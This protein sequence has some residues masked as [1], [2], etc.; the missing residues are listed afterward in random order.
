MLY[1]PR[2]KMLFLLGAVLLLPGIG[3]CGTKVE[4][5]L[6]GLE[7]AEQ[8]NVLALMEINQRAGDEDLNEHVVNRLYR[9]APDQIEKA[10]QPF[11]Y[12]QVKVSSELEKPTA[13][14]AR[15]VAR[16]R[17][18]RGEPAK[19]DAVDYKVTGPGK[20]DAAFP[21]DFGMRP[22]DVLLHAEYEEAVRRLVDI[23]ARNG[24]LDADLETHRVVVDTVRNSARVDVELATGPRYYLGAVTFKQD[25]LD[26]D[27]LRRFVRFQP[28][29]AYDPGKLLGLQ[30]SLLGSEYF[31]QVE[32]VPRK[33][34][35]KDDVIPLDVVATP[36]KA[37]KYRIGGGYATDTGPRLRLDWTR[38]YVGREGHR[39]NAEINVSPALSYLRGEYRIPLEKPTQDM[40]FLRP[41]IE[42]YDT[43]TRSGSLYQFE[44]GHSVVL[45]SGWRRVLGLSYRYEDYKVTGVDQGITNELVPNLFLSKTVT[46]DPVVTR[47]GYRL[48]AGLLGALEQ[49]LSQTSYLSGTLFAKWIGTFGTDYRLITR[50]NLGVTLADSALDLPASR[51]FYAGG[52]ISIRGWGLDVLGPNDPVNNKT[53]GGRYL[54]V[55]SLE[56]ERKI[57]G[58]WGAAIFYDF[59]NAFDPDYAQ[60]VAQGA[61]IGLRWRT[62]VGLVR[63]DV[64]FAVS[65]PDYPARLHV[66][67]GP[68]L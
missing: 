55:G 12:Y 13:E 32:I 38:R 39:M 28:G 21:D 8:E 19:I 67:I 57:Y 18:D 16:Y 41:D 48:E 35:A 53:V 27:F 58:D 4:V 49:V 59:G 46:D 43:T 56:L 50:A 30:A 61:G 65:K 15:W 54:A 62:P 22:G 11:G 9:R 40:L 51:R 7:G 52:D 66:V 1:S 10:L 24:Y 37:N 5:V 42:T 17:V 68:D 23:A 31:D 45:D 34:D 2:K 47:N 3:I 6:E 29:E 36:N 20:E 63:I 64:A 14:G 25:L 26:D 44:A 60:E 33:E